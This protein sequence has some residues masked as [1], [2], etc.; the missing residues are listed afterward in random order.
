VRTPLKRVFSVN[1]SQKGIDEE[2]NPDT[3][4]ENPYEEED[5]KI[6]EME[7]K[8]KEEQE[9]IRQEELEKMYSSVNDEYVGFFLSLDFQFDPS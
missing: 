6:I 7:K 4:Y 9:R 3:D 1:G 2:F 5:Q 8:E